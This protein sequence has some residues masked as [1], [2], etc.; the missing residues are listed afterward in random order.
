MDLIDRAA[1]I[2]IINNQPSLVKQRSE[3]NNINDD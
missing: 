3:D 2:T 1:K